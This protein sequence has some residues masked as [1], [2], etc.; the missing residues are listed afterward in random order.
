MKKQFIQPNIQNGKQYYGNKNILLIFYEDYLIRICKNNK[1]T[2]I[3]KLIKADTIKSFNIIELIIL[4]IDNIYGV[5][6]NL[7]GVKL[8]L[9]LHT[10]KNVAKLN[11]K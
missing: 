5:E 8:N 1:I 11:L 3:S 2:I 7:R 4:T 10:H 9:L 6:A